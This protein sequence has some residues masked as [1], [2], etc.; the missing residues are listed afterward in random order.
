MACQTTAAGFCPRRI[1]E[2]ENLR[3]VAAP[4]HV[5]RSGTMAPLAA[6]VRGT[7]ALMVEGRL[8]MRRFLPGVVNVLMTALAGLRAHVPECVCGRGT[9]HRCAD[10]ARS[11]ALDGS[12][13][14]LT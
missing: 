12:V 10:G 7:A 1:F 6:L 13:R 2:S 11:R 5:V 14:I 4:S 9:A 3:F 8:P